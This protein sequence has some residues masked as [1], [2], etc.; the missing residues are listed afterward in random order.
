[1]E[2]V[3]GHGRIVAGPASPT[4]SA[5]SKL[6]EPRQRRAACAQPSRS[7]AS[8]SARTEAGAR[9]GTRA[10]LRAT[11][12]AQYLMSGSA[13]NDIAARVP[14]TVISAHCAIEL[15]YGDG[16]QS[17]F[18]SASSVRVASTYPTSAAPKQGKPC[19]DGLQRDVL[20]SPDRHERRVP[21]P[22]G[23]TVH[24]DGVVRDAD[25]SRPR[26]ASRP[27]STEAMCPRRTTF[28]IDLSC[29]SSQRRQG[30][31]ALAI[32]GS[33]RSVDP[34]HDAGV[35]EA[36]EQVV[37]GGRRAPDCMMSAAMPRKTAGS[38]WTRARSSIHGSRGSDPADRVGVDALGEQPD[39]GV[40][41]GLARP[42]DDV[43][44]RRLVQVHEVVDRHD[45]RAVAHG[46]RRQHL[47]R[48]AR[49]EVVR[50]DDP[51]R[52]RHLEP[53]TRDARDDGALAVVVAVREELDAARVASSGR[54]SARSR[55]GSPTGWHAPAAR[56][57]VRSSAAC[58]RPAAWTRRRRRRTPGAGGRT[59]RPPAS[60]H[61]PRGGGRRGRRVASEWSIS[62]VGEGHPGRAGAHHEVVDVEPAGHGSTVTPGASAV[63]DPGGRQEV[64]RSS[65]SARR[66]WTA[67]TRIRA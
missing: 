7:R 26:S 47:G 63:H 62:G 17:R 58:H 16:G 18:F 21:Q 61:R 9:A 29:S 52:R 56:P 10:G 14:S 37:E 25:V 30:R 42:D 19:P 8:S 64:V 60:A 57:Q 22:V 1:M 38:G 44:A 5:G 34:H 31:R 3:L 50:V 24:H 39:A 11:P 41:R 15:P 32:V 33:H 6:G 46:E 49:R 20:R 51:A 45:V 2:D 66:D 23:R 40:G 13:E 53:L 35:L 55:R 54:D 28:S 36:E 67:R 12:S 27:R 43:S 4:G 65:W 48:D 59:G